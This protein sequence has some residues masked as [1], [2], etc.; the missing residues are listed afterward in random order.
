M[1][2][3]I[4]NLPD[5]EPFFYRTAAGTEIDLIL[6]RGNRIFAFEFKASAAPR[7]IKGFWTG[8]EDLNVE[9]AWVVAPVNESYPLRENVM[10]C[11][12]PAV[13]RL[14]KDNT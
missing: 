1:E 14:L 10:V 12:L 5:W 6:K 8:L 2:T 13:W 11:S 4:A 9:K 7:L 3:I